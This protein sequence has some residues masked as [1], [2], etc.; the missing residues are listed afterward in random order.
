MSNDGLSEDVERNIR[1]SGL[2][3]SEAVDR[4][5]PGL[6][7]NDVDF[8]ETSSRGDVIVAGGQKDYVAASGRDAEELMRQRLLDIKNGK[9]KLG[10]EESAGNLVVL[11]R[12]KAGK[13]GALAVSFDREGNIQNMLEAKPGTL[14][15]ETLEEQV[16]VGILQDK[17]SA[18]KEKFERDD[19]Y[20]WSMRCR[21]RHGRPALS[22][23]GPRFAKVV[24]TSM[25]QTG[26]LQ[27]G[28]E[29]EGLI[30]G[31]CVRRRRHC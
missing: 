30:L 21:L 8:R 26:S 20:S 1:L 12:E 16:T 23:R 25:R 22:H 15:A 10:N 19:R 9:T 5:D 3:I 18:Y 31:I 28:C 2:K 13:Y 4:L 7:T 11:F 29:P 24:S 17:D 14:L 6:R 27:I